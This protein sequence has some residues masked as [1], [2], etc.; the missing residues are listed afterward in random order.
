MEDLWRPDIITRRP[1]RRQPSTG[2]W[3]I[4]TDDRY[5]VLTMA[6][7]TGVGPTV[8]PESGGMLGLSLV[9]VPASTPAE[10]EG[11]WRLGQGAS[12]RS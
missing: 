2:L 4:P 7:W 9:G 6:P 5:R 11:R 3:P 12:V 10:Q 8:R 1:P